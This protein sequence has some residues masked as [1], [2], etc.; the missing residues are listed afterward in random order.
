MSK[1]ALLK[2]LNEDLAGELG[3]IIR[4]NCQ[5]GRGGRPA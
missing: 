5:A 2:G 1:E 3:T 4:Y